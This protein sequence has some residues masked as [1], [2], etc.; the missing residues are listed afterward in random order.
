[1]TDDRQETG[2][3]RLGGGGGGLNAGEN[4]KFP[5]TSYFTFPQLTQ[6]TPR[7]TRP[8]RATPCTKNNVE[9]VL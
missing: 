4:K 2:E 6:L 5:T 7:I 8:P 1:M 9:R 3:G